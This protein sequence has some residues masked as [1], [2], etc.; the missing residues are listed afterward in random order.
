MGPPRLLGPEFDIAVGDRYFRIGELTLSQL[1]RGMPLDE[2]DMLE[3]DPDA[4]EMD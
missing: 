3:I 4:E 1:K 2:I